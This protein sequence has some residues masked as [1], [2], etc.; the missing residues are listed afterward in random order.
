[1][2][3]RVVVC[4]VVLWFAFFVTASAVGPFSKVIYGEDTREDFVGRIKEDISREYL[5]ITY[6]LLGSVF[7]TNLI[8]NKRVQDYPRS[9]Y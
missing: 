7:S 8:Q 6:F 5:L 9:L 2:S 1:M 3:R 4:G